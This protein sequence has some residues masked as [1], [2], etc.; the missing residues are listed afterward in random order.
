PQ[1]A[2]KR[3]VFP[4]FGFP[5]RA[6]V[7]R[8]VSMRT[9][10]LR[11]GDGRNDDLFRKIAAHGETGTTDGTD[12][13]TPSREF[14]HLQRFTEA[15][16]PELITARTLKMTDLEVTTHFSLSKALEAVY[17]EILKCH[18]C[19]LTLSV[20]ELRHS[21]NNKVWHNRVWHNKG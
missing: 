3:V 12:E 5:A 19:H 6:T 15:E 16:I 7:S 2:L 11:N 17:F 8:D 14:A 13:V 18:A 9:S 1:R 21:C 4:A 20:M 10:L